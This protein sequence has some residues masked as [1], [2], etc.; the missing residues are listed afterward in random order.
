[1]KNLLALGNALV[2]VLIRLDSEEILT[3]LGIA[4]GS[5]QLIDKERFDLIQ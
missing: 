3:E 2:D 1:M 4:K 5:M